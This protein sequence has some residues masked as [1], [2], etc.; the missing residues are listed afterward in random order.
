MLTGEEA[1]AGGKRY[2]ETK[3]AGIWIDA[4]DAA[5]AAKRDT[6]PFRHDELPNGRRTWVDASILGG[7][8]VAYEG[9]T[10][11]FATMIAAGRGGLPVPGHD[12]ISTA[13]TPT[14]TF[15]VDGKFRT[16][17]MVSST[18]SSIVHADVQF[19]QNFHGAHALHGAYWHDGWGELKS[20]GCVN[21][22][23]LDSKWLFE[24]S[25]P[26][27]PKDWHGV[28]SVPELGA[29]TRVVVRP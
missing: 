16:A 2:L 18:D 9:E 26:R 27:L 14:G 22:S 12:P 6:I 7:T 11:V 19:V 4:D 8:L 25:E 28:R 21:L 1:K 23:P 13:S 3:E 24:W 15:R 5:V 10:P 17:T 29:P 20:G